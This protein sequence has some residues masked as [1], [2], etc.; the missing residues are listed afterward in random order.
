[1]PYTFE[2]IGE[3]QIVKLPTGEVVKLRLVAERIMTRK[4]VRERVRALR[5][6]INAL[7]EQLRMPEPS[8]AELIEI[9]KQYHPYYQLDRENIRARIDALQAEIERLKSLVPEVE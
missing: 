6:E 2:G 4:Q 3:E 5:A 7:R 1:M 9:G 8:E